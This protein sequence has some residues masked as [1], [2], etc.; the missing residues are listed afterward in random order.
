M[1]NDSAQTFPGLNRHFC[2]AGRFINNCGGDIVTI[3]PHRTGLALGL[4]LGL[5]HT[6]W[7]MLVAS[8]W[9]QAYIDFIFKLHFIK[10][11]LK[12][13]PFHAGTALLLISITTSIGYLLGW[14]FGLIW[15]KL[16]P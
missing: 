4:T 16:H 1:V 8:G 12:I 9:A 11:D 5:M 3:N 7:A 6:V 2:G 13:E 15:K 10:L 14:T